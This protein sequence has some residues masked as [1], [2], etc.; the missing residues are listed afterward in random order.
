MLPLT[1]LNAA[2]A[3]FDCSF[4]RGCEGVCCREGEPS[5]TPAE[6]AVIDAVLPRARPLLRPEAVQ[7][8]DAGGWLSGEQKLDLPMVRTAGGWCLFFNAG[9]VLHKL[10]ADDGDFSRYK[11]VQC[12]LFPLEPAGDGSG[13]WYVRQRG[14]DGEQWNDLFCLNPA[15]TTRRAVEALAPELAVAAGLGPGFDWGQE[16]AGKSPPPS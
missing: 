13:A 9:C 5:V 1:V 14:Y 3:T 2:T 4:G 7:A 6:R 12:T 10:G 8:L 15:N 16:P 11:P